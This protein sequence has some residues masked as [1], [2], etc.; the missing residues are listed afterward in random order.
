M[1]RHDGGVVQR[2][3]GVRL[4]AL[5]FPV[6]ILAHFEL[7]NMWSLFSKLSIQFVQ[8]NTNATSPIMPKDIWKGWQLR[9]Y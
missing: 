6:N 1:Q 7:N 8:Q 5:L 4:T 9:L 2:F 3:C